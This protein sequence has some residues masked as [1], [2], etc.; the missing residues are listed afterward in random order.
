MRNFI[1]DLLFILGEK[2]N[3]LP[4]IFILF[5]I[6]S[7]IEVL[8]ISI[9]APYISLVDDP[10]KLPIYLSKNFFIACND[11]K[12]PSVPKPQITPLATLLIKDLCLNSSLL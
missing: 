4:I 12:Y 1:S 10:E 11:I 9:L 8:S 2:R 5:F 7:L 6:L 3:H